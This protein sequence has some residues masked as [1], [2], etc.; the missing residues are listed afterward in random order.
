MK[1]TPAIAVATVSNGTPPSLSV[2]ALARGL[3]GERELLLNGAG[4]VVREALPALLQRGDRALRV[5][6]EAQGPRVLEQRVRARVDGGG[7]LAESD[8]PFGAGQ[9]LLR[10]TGLIE[11]VGLQL[12]L[13]R[14]VARDAVALLR[15]LLRLLGLRLGGR[16]GRRLRRR[17]G[18][19]GSCRLLRGGRRAWLVA[20]RRIAAAAGDQRGRAPRDQQQ[21]RERDQRAG[22]PAAT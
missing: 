21:H 1:G 4:L 7:A 16:L 2:A 9:R 13:R 5:A 10:L 19:V 3:A 22:A 20:R 6:G 8:G 14:V 11:V 15:L 17:S 12:E 18:L